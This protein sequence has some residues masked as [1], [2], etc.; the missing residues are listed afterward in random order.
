[1]A[2]SNASDGHSFIRAPEPDLTPEEFIKLA[3]DLKP[4]LKSQQDESDV[5]GT[6][7]QELH[8][9]F[10]KAGFYRALQPR[11]FGGYEFDLP[12]FY[13][14]KRILLCPSSEPH[15]QHWMNSK[16]PSRHR[17]LSTTQCCH[18]PTTPEFNLRSAKRLP[19]PLPLKRSFCRVLTDTWNFAIAGQSADT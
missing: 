14:A 1:M 9:T 7:S 11:M 17:S 4:T 19:V 5:R 8:D 15:A 13:S 16:K 6:Y 18:A 12:T 2:P 3:R 10:R